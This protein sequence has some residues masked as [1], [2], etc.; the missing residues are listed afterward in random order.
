MA[1]KSIG[2]KANTLNT[3]CQMTFAPR[4]MKAVI[5]LREH[6]TATLEFALVLCKEH[7][8]L[9]H[10]GL[11]QWRLMNL[12]RSCIFFAPNFVTLQ[13]ILRSCDRAS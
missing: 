4:C 1:Q 9:S 3:E 8:I 2:A 11:P 6:M 10:L 12:L 5:T 7:T 13:Q